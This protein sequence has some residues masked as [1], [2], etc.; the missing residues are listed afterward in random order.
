[1]VVDVKEI[2]FA[3]RLVR[4]FHENK[5]KSLLRGLCGNYVECSRLLL[6][7]N[8]LTLLKINFDAS[9]KNKTQKFL[10]ARNRQ[11]RELWTNKD[12]L[13]VITCR[14][15]LNLWNV[16]YFRVISA[17]LLCKLRSWSPKWNRCHFQF[18]FCFF[19]YSN[20]HW[21][22]KWRLN[23]FVSF[24]DRRIHSPGHYPVIFRD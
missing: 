23:A 10:P 3:L 21:S 5:S 9:A 22:S 11:T 4:K 14:I 15:E 18:P 19:D 7:I 17:R 24:I 20:R 1:M 8:S 16:F 12:K 13:N 6:K 2:M